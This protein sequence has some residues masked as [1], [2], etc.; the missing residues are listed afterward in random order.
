[1]IGDAL[2]RARPLPARP[3]ATFDTMNTLQPE[4]LLLLA[5]LLRP[6]AARPHRRGDQGDEARR[7]RRHR[8]DRADRLDAR[9]AR[10]ALLRPRPLRRRRAR[11]P[12]RARGSSP[13]TPTASTRSRRPRAAAGRYAPAIALERQAVDAIPLPQ[14]VSRARRPLPRHRPAGARAAAVRADRRD[15]AAA[16]GE[17][18]HA[19]TSRS[20]SSRPTT[21]SRSRQALARARVGRAERPVDR[22]RRRARLDARAERPLRR[23]A[24]LLEA[25]RSGSARR[26]RSSSSTA[27]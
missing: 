14:Y 15:R 19:P 17:R 16:A 13:A 22:R 4:P 26:T 24:P 9:P 3:S 8:H 11:V 25:A 1:M 12:A 27:A 7:R 20:R 6:R 2:D 5:R 18:R 23:G 21:A 10:Q